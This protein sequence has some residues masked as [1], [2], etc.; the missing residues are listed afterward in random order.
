MNPPVK[1]EQVASTMADATMFSPR[2]SNSTATS[3][4][5]DEPIQSDI[6]EWMLEEILL[7]LPVKSI[8]RF[9]S[10]SK[11]WLLRFSEPSFIHWFVSYRARSPQPWTLIYGYT[12]SRSD[13]P[14]NMESKCL[15][16][17]LLPRFTIL[18]S[19][20]NLGNLKTLGSSMGLL[21]CCEPHWKELYYVYSP[22]TRQWVELPKFGSLDNPTGGGIITR[23]RGAEVE[24]Y[25][26]VRMGQKSITPTRLSVDVFSSD[27]GAWRNFDF[28]SPCNTTRFLRLSRPVTINETVY[29]TDYEEGVVV[30]YDPYKI[31]NNLRFVNLPYKATKRL[32]PWFELCDASVGRL[33]YYVVAKAWENPT[34]KVWEIRE[35]G[36]SEP[37]WCLIHS[38]R[39]ME[40]QS[41]DSRI[42][43][44][45]NGDESHSS[46]LPL[47]FD[48]FDK[49][50]MY[51]WNARFLASYDMRTR[52]LEVV[53]ELDGSIR[54]LSWDS[55]V[56]YI[57][58]TWPTHGPPILR[59]S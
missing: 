16:S 14:K 5:G 8:F 48:L 9:K 37:E 50:V 34:I 59:Q 54:G 6:P 40:I 10:V 52:R 27:T 55:T 30:G 57:V 32:P 26:V 15:D 20:Q 1:E 42:L 23:V 49:D 18:P 17:C 33:R 45:L 21:L 19:P 39:W 36:G 44:C 12:R 11:K 58:P 24:S 31:P 51:L 22:I 53:S 7:R 38:C 4:V 46:F 25:K 28:Q 13:I 3:F 56:P 47:S 2:P 35:P 29:M 41:G 43:A